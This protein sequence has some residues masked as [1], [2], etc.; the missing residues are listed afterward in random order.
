MIIPTTK[1]Y[2]N[3][4]LLKPKDIQSLLKVEKNNY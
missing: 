3:D 2:I 4:I 1:Y